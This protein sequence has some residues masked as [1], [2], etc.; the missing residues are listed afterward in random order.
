MLDPQCLI[1]NLRLYAEEDIRRQTSKGGWRLLGSLLALAP[2]AIFWFLS[3]ALISQIYSFL[4][5]AAAVVFI[6]TY[7]TFLDDPVSTRKYHFKDPGKLVINQYQQLPAL[8]LLAALAALFWL[9]WKLGLI[10][11]I[12][13]FVWLSLCLYISNTGARSARNT[14]K[15]LGSSFTLDGLSDGTQ[16]APAGQ[17][18]LPRKINVITGTYLAE[19]RLGNRSAPAATWTTADIEANQIIVAAAGVDSPQGVYIGSMSAALACSTN[20]NQRAPGSVNEGQ[21]ADSRDMLAAQDARI[22]RRSR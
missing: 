16:D 20:T 18:A 4:F 10:F 21:R 5:A 12:A 22:L 2:L 6:Q 15:G 17:Q 3:D 8:A 19:D 13:D 1:V 14:A 7:L 11:A 9:N